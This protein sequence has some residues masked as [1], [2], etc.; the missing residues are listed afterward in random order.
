MIDCNAA[1][2]ALE[3]FIGR[4]TPEVAAVAREVRARMRTRLPRATELV[5]DN[6]NQARHVVLESAADLDDPA[7]QALMA[8]ALERRPIDP[9]RPRRIIIRSVSARQ[10]AR[11][12]A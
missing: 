12:P 11:R 5:Y 7:L 1:E 2:R 6:H 3:G 10:R 9:S 8:A 4:Y